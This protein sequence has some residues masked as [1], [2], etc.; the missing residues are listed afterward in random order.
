MVPILLQKV[1]LKL[2]T[3]LILKVWGVFL[4]CCIKSYLQVM[5][6]SWLFRWSKWC[7]WLPSVPRLIPLFHLNYWTLWNGR[8]SLRTLSVWWSHD[9]T[10]LARKM[11]KSLNYEQ[12][13]SLFCANIVCLDFLLSLP[14]FSVTISGKP[15]HSSLYLGDHEA[16]QKGFVQSRN[17]TG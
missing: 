2:W 1:S 14:R 12:W 9:V 8:C 10:F 17:W 11:N 13:A 15:K 3:C 7:R 16:Y 4:L 5:R 6:A